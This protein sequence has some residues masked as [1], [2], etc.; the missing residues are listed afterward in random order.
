MRSVPTQRLPG[1]RGHGRRSAASRPAVRALLI[2]AVAAAS[3]LPA[4]LGTVACQSNA[5]CPG[6]AC[7]TAHGFCVTT[8]SGAGGGTGGGPGLGGGQ[9][10]GAG[11]APDASSDAGGSDAGPV[12]AGR[13]DAGAGDAGQT[14]AGA[15][16]AG[17]PDAGTADAGA[18]DAG[19]PDAGSADAGATDAGV[20][21]GGAPDA[22][23]VGCA[24]NG[25]FGPL[26]P[27]QDINAR[28]TA[29]SRFRFSRDERELWYARN[30]PG[31]R[32][33]LDLFHAVR[34]NRDAGFGPDDAL[35]GITTTAN[36][37]DPMP[38]D[39]G[40]LLYY[41]SSAA[42]SFDLY[43][44]TAVGTVPNTWALQGSLTFAS[45]AAA[46]EFA[47]FVSSAGDLWFTT[48]PLSFTPF[49]VSVA[50]RGGMGSF[51]A[52]VSDP[53]LQAFMGDGG[54]EVRTPVVS[55]DGLTLYVSAHAAGESWF[56]V[57]RAH[58]TS[59]A[60]PFPPPTAVPEL[61]LGAQGQHLDTAWLSPDGCRL[62]VMAWGQPVWTMGVFER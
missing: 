29:F 50:P 61:D 5:D 22:G 15:I 54:A 17:S 7:D 31:V 6:G 28:G 13:S 56:H 25:V 52:P 12:D 38:V 51:L 48:S 14:D 21:D 26:T 9:G 8:G 62:Y 60:Q 42:G 11:G 44:A 10:G 35:L 43:V 46:V 4:C 47:P 41:S 3:L 27:M 33:D 18:A 57:F 49:T 30:L 20:R 19:T 36:E 40:G 59:T 58:R 55:D 1:P 45:S 2:V 24:W 23:P 37:M 16:D 39:D 32:G 53:G 34:S